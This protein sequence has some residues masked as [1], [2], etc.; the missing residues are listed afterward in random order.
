MGRIFW[1]KKE[2]FLWVQILRLLNGSILYYCVF[3]LVLKE[4]WVSWRAVP[5][6]RRTHTIYF[7][8][9]R[10]LMLFPIWWIGKWNFIWQA[11]WV[12]QPTYSYICYRRAK[13]NINS[14]RAQ[15]LGGLTPEQVK[16]LPLILRVCLHFNWAWGSVSSVWANS[17]LLPAS[18][19]WRRQGIYWSRTF[20]PVYRFPAA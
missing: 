15:I 7:R 12:T 11:A 19:D 6:T 17:T 20:S 14:I 1:D 2:D 10:L 4:T 9:Q 8:Q 13:N 3:L 16:I 18:E 5:L